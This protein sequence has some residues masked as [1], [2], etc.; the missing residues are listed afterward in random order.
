MRSRC[1]FVKQDALATFIHPISVAYSPF[2]R[3]MSYT[4]V[5]VEIH[6]QIIDAKHNTRRRL[7]DRKAV[8]GI[9]QRVALVHSLG[10]QG[11]QNHPRPLLAH[12][13]WRYGGLP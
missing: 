9:E 4:R 2:V 7:E 8:D 11:K 13:L 3:Y 1:S 5:G 6:S 12:L 10:N